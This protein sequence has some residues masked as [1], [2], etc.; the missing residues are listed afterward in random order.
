MQ[1]LAFGMAVALFGAATASAQG[2]PESA[3]VI[4]P[5]T[6]A[7]PAPCI[8]CLAALTPVELVIDAHLG[9]KISTT[10][11]T[12]P[13]HLGK[14]I[15]VA[16]R[17]VIAA[18]VV[19]EGEVI[20]AKKAGGMGSAGELVL[21]ARFV[22]VDGRPLKLRSMRVAMAGKDAIH[23]VDSINAASV[24]S[25]LPIGLIGFFMSGSN[26]VVPKGTTAE[27]KTAVDFLLS[28]TGAGSGTAPVTTAVP[29][30]PGPAKQ[31]E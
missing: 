1:K 26:V 30:S 31:G 12:F 4:A 11:A 27:A 29:T 5:A 6:P 21:A 10:G 23:T 3:A 18:G 19:G 25:P 9:S 2:A 8:D 16:G 24:V 15:L 22:M 7:I 17:E 28:P 20:H 14:P 13:L